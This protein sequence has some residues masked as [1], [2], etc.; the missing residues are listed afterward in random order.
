VNQ[1]LA[2]YYRLPEN[3][4][5]WT[6]RGAGCESGNE[7]FFRFGAENVCFGRS[8][9]GVAAEFAGSAQF[10]ASRKVY[11]NGSRIQLPFHFSEVIDNLRLERYRRMLSPPR[12]TLVANGLSRK[13]YYLIREFLPVSSRREL[14]RLYFSNWKK[15]PFPVWPVDFTVDNLHE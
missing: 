10:D 1:T 2:D 5:L 3:L 12:D 4:P 7:G 13:L 6:A 8:Q 15:L 9:A 11:R 14:Q